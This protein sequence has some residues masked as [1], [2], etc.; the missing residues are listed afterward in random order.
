ML[1]IQDIT[2]KY[3]FMYEVNDQIYC[4]GQ[5]VYGKLEIQ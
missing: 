1:K 4:M 5:G 2:K 3:P